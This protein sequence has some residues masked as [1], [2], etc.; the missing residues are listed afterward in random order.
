MTHLTLD[1]RRKGRLRLEEGA[2]SCTYSWVVVLI[3]TLLSPKRT[4][5]LYQ[6]QQKRLNGRFLTAFISVQYDLISEFNSEFKSAVV[7][8]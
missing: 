2:Q 5:H 4:A 3:A 1:G 6:P 8:I 7:F